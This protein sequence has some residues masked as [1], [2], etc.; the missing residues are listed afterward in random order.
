MIQETPIL[1]FEFFYVLR[2][3]LIKQERMWYNMD[4]RIYTIKTSI[5]RLPLTLNYIL[6]NSFVFVFCVFFAAQRR[7][8]TKSQS[9]L[10]ETGIRLKLQIYKYTFIAIFKNQLF[11]NK[12]LVFIKSTFCSVFI[13]HFLL[14]PKLVNYFWYHYQCLPTL[15]VNL[16]GNSIP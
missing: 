5:N 2:H 4:L 8:Q 1:V 14:F 10:P 12:K 9:Q 11:T 3:W 16:K 13:K 15:L 7:K 6:Q